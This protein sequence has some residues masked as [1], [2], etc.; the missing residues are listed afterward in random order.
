MS[1]IWER[2]YT[3]V[4]RGQCFVEKETD[5]RVYFLVLSATKREFIEQ[6]YIIEEDRFLPCTSAH[7]ESPQGGWIPELK[8]YNC[9]HILA[10]KILME[11]NGM[12]D[13]FKIRREVEHGIISVQTQEN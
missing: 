9:T 11:Q 13:R 5:R 8:G 3:L 4:K 10:C 7:G 12:E 2:A 6:Q 1:T